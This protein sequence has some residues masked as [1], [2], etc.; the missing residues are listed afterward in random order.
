MEALLPVLRG[1]PIPSVLVCAL[2]FRVVDQ[3]L[4]KLPVPKV[5]QQDKFHSW[6][7]RNLSVSM[8]H[9]LIT[10]TWAVTCAVVW[11]ETLQ[12]LHLYQTPLSYLLVCVSTGYFMQDA[13]D[14]IYRGHARGSWEFLLHHVLV[15]SCF[16]YALCTQK[17]VN[18]AVVALFVEVN[19][20]TLHLRL[21]LKLAGAQST[22]LYHINKV[23]NIV[24]YVIFRLFTQF[25]LTWFILHNYAKLDHA[26]FF[27]FC[28]MLMN[29]MIGIYLYR[30]I[31]S[32]FFIRRKSNITE[33]GTHNN[34]SRKFLTD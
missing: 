21:L 26:G 33:N 15:L 1:Y 30:L 9:S 7:W 20:V 23:V 8:V 25:Y 12:D 10:G 18:G 3:L 22:P 29:I 2:L 34:N 27:F 24:T 14:I 5:V 19:S 4:Q 17:Y 13:C 16:L 11:P 32:D 28:M 6:R 31:R